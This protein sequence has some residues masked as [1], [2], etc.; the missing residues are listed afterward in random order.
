M[1]AVNGKE[2]RKRRVNLGLKIGEFA[3]AAR[4]APKT[5]ANIESAGSQ[6]CAIEVVHRFAR[7]L[8]TKPED[9]LL[10]TDAAA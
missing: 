7:I 9:L 1:P 8:G 4:I 2:I 5:V 6:A 10:K 3:E